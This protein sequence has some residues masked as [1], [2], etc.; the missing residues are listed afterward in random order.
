MAKSLIFL[1]DGTGN[2]ATTT[3]DNF[4]NVYALNQL[5]AESNTSSTD[6]PRT[7]ITFYMPGLGTGFTVRR[8]K[9]GGFPLFTSSD[10]VRQA[11]FGDGL[12]QLILRAYVNLSANYRVGDQIICVG[13]SRG[14]VAARIFTRLIS[15]FG[16]LISAK[17]MLLDKIW[18]EF[19]E[20]S[21][22][23]DDSIYFRRIKEIKTD[24]CV[25]FPGE[26]VFHSTEVTKVRFLGLF[27]TVVGG[28]DGEG[29][30]EK[31]APRDLRPASSVE[32]IV[33]LMSMHEVRASFP[34]KRFEVSAARRPGE[35]SVREIWLPGVHSDVGGGYREYLIGHLSLLTM[36]DL[37]SDR[38][39]VE[40]DNG[41][42]QQIVQRI[43][44]KYM[45]GPV[46][47]NTEPWVD[48]R[49]KRNDLIKKGD[50][51]HPL[52]WHMVGKSV[53]WKASEL[54]QPYQSLY[55]KDLYV[56]DGKLRAQMTSWLEG[57][58]GS[59][60]ATKPTG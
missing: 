11:I 57:T 22:E 41:A 40:I 39:G 3:N 45:L 18:N 34:L 29:E 19:I 50:E 48:V 35:T 53:Y 36:A 42:Y 9:R 5:I 23:I 44:A 54:P 7:Q 38:G 2:D 58:L 60:S 13:F 52:H 20:I 55:D 10:R 46:F 56:E 31:F 33:H 30:G 26:D 21:S 49:R 4:S 37:I 28:L 27:D 1:F 51:I 6:G 8:S 15:D 32:N 25:A 59:L 43:R 24:L 16:V 17:L 12:E 14:A 47:V